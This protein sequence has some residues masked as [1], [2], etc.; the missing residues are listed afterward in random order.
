MRI[1]VGIVMGFFSGVMIYLGVT[2]LVTSGTPSRALVLVSLLGDWLLSTWLIVQGARTVSKVF[3]C[4]FLLGAAE[5]LAM[6][7]IGIISSGRAVARTVEGG[8]SADADAAGATMLAGLAALLGSGLAV[9]MALVCMLGFAISYFIGREMKPEIATPT[10]S[11]PE[12]AELI[13]AAA[14]KCKHCGAEIAE[15]PDAGDRK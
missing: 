10:K 14:R 8:G 13:L 7:P 2:S 1:V 5:W 9:V 6:I 12:C 3:S 11:C 15:A 4:G